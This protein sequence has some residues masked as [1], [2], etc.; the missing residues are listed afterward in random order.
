M[1]VWPIAHDGQGR[2]FDTFKNGSVLKA[3]GEPE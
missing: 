2:D 1:Q 3:L